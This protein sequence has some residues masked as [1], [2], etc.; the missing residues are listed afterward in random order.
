MTDAG[1]ALADVNRAFRTEYLPKILEAAA[2]KEVSFWRC[3][4]CHALIS[5]PLK[6]GGDPS[7]P[8]ECIFAQG[9]C[10]REAAATK[11]EFVSVR[12]TPEAVDAAIV[13]VATNEGLDGTHLRELARQSFALSGEVNITPMNT[14]PSVESVAEAMTRIKR[15]LRFTSER[16]YAAFLLTAGQTH[17]VNLLESVIYIGFRG[18][19]GSGKGTAVES[20]VLLSPDGIVL[21]DTTEAYL[22]ATLDAG[23]TIGIE[24]ADELLKA[25][26][27]GVLPALLRN[28]YRRGATYGLMAWDESTKR[29]RPD[30]RSVFGPKAFDF[31]DTLET[32]LLGRTV[33]IA[34]SPDNSVDR[35]MDAEH[36]GHYLDGVR[37]WLAQE[38]EDAKSQWTPDAVRER[39]DSSEFRA[40]VR[41][42]GGKAGRDHVIAAYLLLVADIFGWGFD[43]AIREIVGGRTRFE[44]HGEEAEVAEYI[45]SMVPGWQ[46]ST[47]E[48]VE[49][50]TDE[51]LMTINDAR[52][53]LGQ[54][55][56][57]RRR[58]GAVLVDLGFNSDK[59]ARPRTWYRATRGSNRGRHVIRPTS[60]VAKLA[61]ASGMRR[62]A[63]TQLGPSAPGSHGDN[64]GDAPDGPDA[65]VGAVGG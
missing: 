52:K 12:A 59:Q 5:E 24:E 13:K 1:P 30:Q 31:H 62:E 57:T 28:G 33:V 3:A 50:S 18:A 47:P 51:L 6:E 26:A 23:R 40:R 4:R 21:S 60:L 44:E 42:M 16:D 45:L 14:E 63:T 61:S 65:P 39:W 36:K 53:A 35:A 49:L 64:D 29:W 37:S 25:N 38:A 7:P 9:G 41:S 56:M 15:V 19:T 2:A 20:Y 11:F 43:D 46:D 17:V 32:H 58:L 10:G 22:A 54:Y 8:E 55:P 34:L 48:D 27:K